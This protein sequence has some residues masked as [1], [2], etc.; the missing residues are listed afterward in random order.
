MPRTAG[1][2]L[3]LVFKLRSLPNSWNGRETIPCAFV[4]AGPNLASQDLLFE[5]LEESL[6]GSTENNKFVRLRSADV[7]NTKAALKKIIQDITCK[8]SGDEDG[9]LTIGKSVSFLILERTRQCV[10]W[11]RLTGDVSNLESKVPKL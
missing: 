1:I 3:H 9:Q 4:V 11:C 10:R 8:A 2:L 5:Q 6:V 7:S